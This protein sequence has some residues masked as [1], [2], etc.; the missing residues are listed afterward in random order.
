MLCRNPYQKGEAL[1]PCGQ[2]LPC[3]LNRRR[4]WTHRIMLEALTHETNGFATLTYDGGNVPTCDNRLGT[5]DPA[6]V[7]CWLKRLRKAVEPHRIRYYVV[8]EYGDQTWRPH[9]HAAL[10]G[11][12]PESEA[13]VQSTWGK[14]FASVG[15]L[16]VQSAAYVAGYV[17]KKMTSKED[18]RLKGRYP[19]FA[20]ISTHPG[21]GGDAMWDVASTLLEFEL[22]GRGDVPLALRHGSRVMPLGRY[23]TRR[24]R[25]F[26][27][28]AEEAPPETI[29][30]ASAELQ[31]VRDI[32]FAPT[33]P[34][35]S[36]GFLYKALAVEAN[37]QKYLQ[38][39][40][41][42]SIF[43]KRSAL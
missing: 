26:V 10:F 31:G 13:V 29:A 19:E 8:G 22:E 21:L 42:Q 39:E 25:R 41:R 20:R 12:G 2:C 15:S 43:K 30:L 24:L 37:D 33:V 32:A 5:L 4:V 38:L 36:R 7:T 27:G 18:P 11:I 35:Q 9:Y 6:D 40:A 3:R 14:G 17:T 1:Y 34:R 23:L 16:T 28:H